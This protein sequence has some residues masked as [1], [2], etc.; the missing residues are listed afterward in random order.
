MV[1]RERE[2]LNGR[3]N[4]QAKTLCQDAKGALKAYSRLNARSRHA[5]RIQERERDNEEERGR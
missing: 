5:G 3:K 2:K 1:E 4:N